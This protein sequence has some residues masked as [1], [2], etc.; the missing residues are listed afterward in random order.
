MSCQ[1]LNFRAAVDVH[2]LTDDTNPDSIVGYT[3]DI[4]IFCAECG[5]PFQFLGIP[6]GVSFTNNKPMVSL[7]GTELRTPIIPS[8]DPVDQ[9]HSLLTLKTKDG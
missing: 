9:V 3:S 8:S 1:H 7:D 2:R 5:I 6:Q 4:H